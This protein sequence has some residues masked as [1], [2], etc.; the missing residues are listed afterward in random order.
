MQT[1]PLSPASESSP[2]SAPAPQLYLGLPL[3]VHGFAWSGLVVLTLLLVAL[4][5]TFEGKSVWSGWIESRG[6]RQPSYAERIYFDHVVRTRANTW[7]NLAFVVVGLYALALG[8]HDRRHR[9]AP[10]AG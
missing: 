8:Y 4:T 2:T 7:S 5:A 3:R 1:A 9:G 6:L 10:R